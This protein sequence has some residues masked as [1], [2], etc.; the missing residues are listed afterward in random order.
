MYLIWCCLSQAVFI[1]MASVQFKRCV[2]PCLRFLTAG[3]T[4]QLCVFTVCQYCTPE[5]PSRE[6]PV[7]TVKPCRSECYAPT[8]LCLIRLTRLACSAVRVR[9]ALRWIFQKGSRLLRHILSPPL[10]V[11]MFSLPVRKP[12][13]WPLP[14]E[15]RTQ[16]LSCLILRN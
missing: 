14:H 10:T 3:D 11:P 13:P 6:L 4:H 15:R 9:R 5:Q 1:I 2:Y 12:A 8:W 16:C 7:R